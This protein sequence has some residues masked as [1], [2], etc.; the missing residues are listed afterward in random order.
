ME[1]PE[2]RTLGLIL[3]IHQPVHRSRKP[4]H[5]MRIPRALAMSC[6]LLK[7]LKLF[8]NKQRSSVLSPSS[9]Q[10]G[11]KT[12]PGTSG[13]HRGPRGNVPVA[14]VPGTSIWGSAGVLEVAHFQPKKHSPE[15]PEMASSTF[16]KPFCCKPAAWEGPGGHPNR[17]GAAGLKCGAYIRT[18]HLTRAVRRSSRLC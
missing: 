4:Q 13:T 8:Q 18:S 3:E 12:K 6:L 11:P 16:D 15:R 10:D 5:Q 2:C 1:R 9:P 17:R 14:C 7:V